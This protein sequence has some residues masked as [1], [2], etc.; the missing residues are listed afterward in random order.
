MP[1]MSSPTIE[2][3]ITIAADPARVFAA[4]TTPEEILRYFPFDSV[5]LDGRVGGEVVFHGSVG[6]APFTDHGTITTWEPG[7]EFAYAYWSDNHGRPRT[8][9][10]HA[11]LRYLLEPTSDGRTRLRIEHGN[12]PPGPY[13][14]E[15]DGA[16][17]MLLSLLAAHVA[18][19]P[20]P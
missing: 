13:L 14:E 2:K 1:G 12:L 16:W 6:G 18:T 8:P 20:R 7:R 17:G 3:E 19:S 9:E 4:L 5:E 11:T 10:H 15:M